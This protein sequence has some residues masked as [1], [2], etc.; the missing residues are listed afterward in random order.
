MGVVVVFILAHLRENTK[1]IQKVDDDDDEEENPNR[2][3]ETK[4]RKVQIDANKHSP[5]SFSSSYSPFSTM[6]MTI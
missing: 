4:K 6:N 2:E 3:K 1:W 5:S